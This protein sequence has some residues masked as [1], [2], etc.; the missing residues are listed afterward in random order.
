MKCTKIYL[1]GYNLYYEYAFG[2]NKMGPETWMTHEWLE[3][4]QMYDSYDPTSSRVASLTVSSRCQVNINVQSFTK[5]YSW[6]NLI[7]GDMWRCFILIGPWML[8]SNLIGWRF[9]HLSFY[10]YIVTWLSIAICNF[11]NS[12]FI[13]RFVLWTWMTLGRIQIQTEIRQRSLLKCIIC[14]T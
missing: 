10:F 14:R 7:P 1:K 5:I 4:T 3:M 11:L 12:R 9:S 6:L 2:T 8:S 13:N